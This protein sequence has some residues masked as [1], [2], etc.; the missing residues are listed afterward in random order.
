MFAKS[1]FIYIGSMFV[2]DKNSDSLKTA[3]YNTFGA[4]LGADLIFGNLRVVAFAGLNNIADK[5]YVAF[6]QIN[7]NVN[8]F[9]EA[10]AP[11]NFFGGINLSYIFN[12]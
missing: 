11:R 6:V 10:G 2:D 1:N 12:R 9:Y 7:S 8:Q 4:Q 5:K 3:S